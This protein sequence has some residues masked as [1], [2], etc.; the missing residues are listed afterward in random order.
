MVSGAANVYKTKGK[1][2]KTIYDVWSNVRYYQKYSKFFKK[3][4]NL[5]VATVFNF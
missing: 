4:L 5:K 3:I 1:N 2:T